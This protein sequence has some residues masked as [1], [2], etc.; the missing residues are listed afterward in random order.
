MV[1]GLAMDDF[2][3]TPSNARPGEETYNSFLEAQRPWRWLASTV[4]LQREAFGHDP[5]LVSED[6]EK[7]CASLKDNTFQA[8]RELMEA[9]LEFKSKDWS[10]DPPYVNR[11][12]LVVELVDAAHFI[13]NMLVNLR[14]TDEEWEALYRMKQDRNRR[15]M[16]SGNYSERKGGLGDGSEAE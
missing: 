15:R 5:L 8:I 6:I 11:T 7:L 2:I 3:S 10:V 4:E 12:P 16:E 13:A 14:V 9:S 1:Y